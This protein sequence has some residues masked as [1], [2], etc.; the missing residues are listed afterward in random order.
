MAS[1]TQAELERAEEVVGNRLSGKTGKDIDEAIPIA[2]VEYD[3]VLFL[4]EVSELRGLA[5]SIPAMELADGPPVP[6][7]LT[8]FDW[9]PGKGPFSRPLTT[10]N[11]ALS[12][13]YG[14]WIRSLLKNI[15]PSYRGLLKLTPD[16]ARECFLA[17]AGQFLATRF[18][19]EEHTSELQQ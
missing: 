3:T 2:D 4:T 15:T 12:S 1:Y 10:T 14:G 5:H 6:V 16:Q 9:P 17:R 13:E 7:S 19:S 8:S 11:K 18:R